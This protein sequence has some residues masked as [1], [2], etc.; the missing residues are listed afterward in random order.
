MAE[1]RNNQSSVRIEEID[2]HWTV[3]IFE[4][5][6]TVQETFE[7]EEFARNFADGQQIRLGISGD[8]GPSPS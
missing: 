6:D 3:F 2:G 1:E 4:D 5:G 7:T 8:K